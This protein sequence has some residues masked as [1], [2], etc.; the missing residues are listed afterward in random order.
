[1]YSYITY[2]WTSVGNYEMSLMFHIPYTS[3]L[4][5]H[6]IKLIC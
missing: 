4:T 5:E 1:M 2:T 6:K 3:M